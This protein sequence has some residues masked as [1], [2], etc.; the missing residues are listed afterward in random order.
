VHERLTSIILII[1][2]K[3]IDTLLFHKPLILGHIK[4]EVYNNPTQ[5]TSKE[6]EKE[7]ALVSFSLSLS[8]KPSSAKS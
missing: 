1:A 2:S 3:V 4:I 5:Y 7:V 8:Y 6:G